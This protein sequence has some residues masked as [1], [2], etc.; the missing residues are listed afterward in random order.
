MQVQ[1][2]STGPKAPA[3][4][5]KP[6]P[7]K[8][9]PAPKTAAA[10]AVARTTP[11]SAASPACAQSD[12]GEKA[13]ALIRQVIAE[14]LSNPENEHIRRLMTD[15]VVSVLSRPPRLVDDSLQDRVLRSV[16]AIS[17]SERQRLLDEIFAMINRER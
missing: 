5:I 12:A 3:T 4:K 15:T 10:A 1:R 6:D 8:M 11:A 16:A 9:K 2:A 14:E 13:K 7:V 17:A